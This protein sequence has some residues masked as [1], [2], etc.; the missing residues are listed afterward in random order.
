MNEAEPSPYLRDYEDAFTAKRFFR[1]PLPTLYHV[2]DTWP[3]FEKIR[4]VLDRRFSEW[5]AK[6]S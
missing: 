3:S 4:S 1:N 6:L 5:R 2:P